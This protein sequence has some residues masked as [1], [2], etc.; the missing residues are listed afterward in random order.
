MSVPDGLVPGTQ[1]WPGPACGELLGSP[2]VQ[3]AAVHGRAPGEASEET[4]LSH[5]SLHYALPSTKGH[6][7]LGGGASIRGA[8]IVEPYADA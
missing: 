2:H 8:E 3:C 7:A 4:L 6:S 1:G 5:T